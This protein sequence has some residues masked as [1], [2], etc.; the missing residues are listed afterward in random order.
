VFRA[1]FLYI[2]L[3]LNVIYGA[4]MVGLVDSEG[5]QIIDGTINFLD[6]FALF[7][8]AL[9][10]FKFVFAAIYVIQWNLRFCCNPAFKSNKIDVPTAFKKIRKDK[11]A[12]ES[13]DEEDEFNEEGKKGL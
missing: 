5:A 9:V 3:V 7:V 10:I 13:S 4:L 11:N 1:H 6:G 12:Q 2:W 8:A